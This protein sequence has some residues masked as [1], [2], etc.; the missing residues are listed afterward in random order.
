M[1]K[2]RKSLELITFQSFSGS[3][4]EGDRILDFMYK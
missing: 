4:L 2:K 3:G 1:D